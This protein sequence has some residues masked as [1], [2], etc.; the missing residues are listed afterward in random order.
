MQPFGSSTNS[1]SRFWGWTVSPAASATI[2]VASMPSSSPNSFS[3][4]A[5]R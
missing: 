3:M 4:T 5:M 1:A 2:S